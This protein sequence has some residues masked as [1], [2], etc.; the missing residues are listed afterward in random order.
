MFIVSTK[1][2][3]TDYKQRNDSFFCH[4]SVTSLKQKIHISKIFLSFC[5]RSIAATLFKS[6]N[7]FCGADQNANEISI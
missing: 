6:I 1:V 5:P 2:K 4:L 3:A 7:N